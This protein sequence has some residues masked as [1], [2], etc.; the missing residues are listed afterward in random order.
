[1][2]ALLPL[3]GAG[4]AGA[5]A[6]GDTTG[7]NTPAMPNAAAKPG[8]IKAL[9][10][11]TGG[12]LVENIPRVLAD[13]MTVHLDGASWK[14]GCPPVF[15][16]IAGLGSV[17]LDDMFRT[18]NCGIGMCVVVAKEDAK[19]VLTDLRARGRAPLIGEVRT[20][21]PDEDRVLPV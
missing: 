2:K 7:N 6:A 9:A 1:M 10:H 20:T 13:G 4:N 11:I 3:L 17:P 14:E 8:K 19:D 21:S 16:W 12:G 18:F 15:S 5:A